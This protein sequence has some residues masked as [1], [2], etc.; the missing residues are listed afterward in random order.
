MADDAQL[1]GN[2]DDLIP[3]LSASEIPSVA[4]CFLSDQ[5]KMMAR[6]CLRLAG[7]HL[8]SE[9]ASE[10]SD[11]EFARSVFE[12]QFAL[13]AHDTNSDP[14]FNYANRT[15]LNLF[16]M[17]WEEFT[18]LPSRLSAE[19]VHRDERARL[20]AQVREKGFISDYSGVRISKSGKR[21]RIHAAT[22]FN[23]EDERGKP[24]GQA[25]LFRDWTEL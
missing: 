5:V 18:A 6:S 3:T 25:A 22:V 21:F 12:A 24:C 10:L 17:T 2:S 19:P 7:L 8:L 11:A 23:L 1:I 16:E 4:N 20:M 14:I 9:C 15:A 13:V